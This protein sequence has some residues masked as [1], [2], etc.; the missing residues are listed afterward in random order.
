MK[1]SNTI[2]MPLHFLKSPVLNLTELPKLC[3]EETVFEVILEP[4]RPLL[5]NVATPL[6]FVT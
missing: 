4:L 6:G 5:H 2:A 1:C 3:M